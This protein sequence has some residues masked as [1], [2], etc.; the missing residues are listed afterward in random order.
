MLRFV[1]AFVFGCGVGMALVT[2]YWWRSDQQQAEA[3][4]GWEWQQK[5]RDLPSPSREG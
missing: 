4:E 1:V 3:L 5:Q 2:F